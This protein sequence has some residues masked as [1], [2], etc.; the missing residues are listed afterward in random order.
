MVR[1]DGRKRIEICLSCV[2]RMILAMYRPNRTNLNKLTATSCG[3]GVVIRRRDLYSASITDPG[4]EC[5]NID[6][7][8]T[9][10]AKVAY[11]IK[12]EIL[13]MIRQELSIAHRR[14]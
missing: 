13:A 12:P 14:G 3:L 5:G 11:S 7:Y 8:G 1:V 4:S 6:R 9:A 2:F 10:D